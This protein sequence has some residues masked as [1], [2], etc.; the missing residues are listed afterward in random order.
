LTVLTP[1]LLILDEVLAVGDLGFQQKC[2]DHLHRLRKRG[3]AIV[4]ASHDLAQI[5]EQCERVL[6]IDGGRMKA[7][8]DAGSVIEQYQQAVQAETLRVTPEKPSSVDAGELVLNETR[9]GSQEMQIDRVLAGAPG[10]PGE[11]AS[12]ERLDVVIR[13]NAVR[14]AEPLTI[15]V[16]ISR[17]QDE[18]KCLDVNTGLDEVTVDSTEGAPV[19]ATLSLDSLELR[20]GSYWVDV[21]VF[22]LDWSY[23]YD[24]HWHVHPLTVT[25]SE[26]DAGAV[27]RPQQR[28]WTVG[29]E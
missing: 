18:V 27:Y 8:G 7:L 16:S 29:R 12:G 1:D 20:P 15:S 11:V 28:R 23:A 17:Q 13:V 14:R 21:G 6:L 19:S 5:A 22:P 24:Y 2:M 3:T 4:L 10:S 26:D 25:G 9:F